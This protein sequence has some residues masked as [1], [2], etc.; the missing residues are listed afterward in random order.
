MY[1][2][3]GAVDGFVIF[4][5]SGCRERIETCLV[6]Q[7]IRNRSISLYFGAGSG[8][9]HLRPR[10]SHYQRRKVFSEVFHQNED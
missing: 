10:Q 2:M 3:G 4:L 7:A 1:Q 5:Y 8:L 9:K 6:Q